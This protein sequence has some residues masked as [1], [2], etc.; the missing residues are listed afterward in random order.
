M[1]GKPSDEL[2]R[3]VMMQ[4]FSIRISDVDLISEPTVSQRNHLTWP[5]FLRF[6][7][8]QVLS[9]AIPELKYIYKM[10][11]VD[12]VYNYERLVK[13]LCDRNRPTDSSSK[14]N[15]PPSDRETKI[16]VGDIAVAMS[17]TTELSEIYNSHLAKLPVFSDQAVEMTAHQVPWL[18]F[19]AVGQ[20]SQSNGFD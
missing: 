1:T 2:F 12:R 14:P 16:G 15:H 20:P 13:A 5:Q 4:V 10:R 7:E 18:V 19:A 8:S 11:C 3:Q 17:L 9:V 6:V